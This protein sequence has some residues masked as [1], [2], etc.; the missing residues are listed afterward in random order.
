MVQSFSTL[1]EFYTHG[2]DTVIDVRSPSEFGEDHVP[3][4]INLPV[5]DDAERAE[6][7]TIYVQDSPFK[8]RKIGAALVAKNSS[9]HLRGPL[10]DHPGEWK[11]LVYCWRGGQRSGSFTS[12][13]NQIGWRA[14]VVEG[15]YRAYRRLVVKALYED[16]FRAPVYLIDGNTGTAKTDIL[17]AFG[18]LGGQIIDLEGLAHHRGSLF[19][20]FG[21]EQP[22]QK[23]F[24]G[25]LAKAVHGLDASRPVLIEAESSKI[26]ERM[27]PPSIWA[28][29][30]DA[31]RV[32][33]SAPLEARAAYL[34]R[35]YC[36]LTTDPGRLS[37]VIDQLR[38]F[39]SAAQIDGWQAMAQ[40]GNFTRLAGGLMEEH[41]DPRY[42]KT[43]ASS[44]LS[45]DL[46]DLN[47]GD[48][49]A[50]AKEI[51]SFLS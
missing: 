45:L 25:A 8:A 26:G 16:E 20:G 47:G 10:C 40:E 38:P 3:G 50:A 17:H 27:V 43:D 28:A 22:S 49:E 12:I 29:M 37:A 44:V 11:P 42:R 9:I 35:A 51:L 13:L 15:G 14:E 23:A 41:Y 36:D 18:R 24:E 30:K 46:R 19:G 31:P 1:S 7:G 6:V 48:I 34:T 39:Y 32:R 5:L 33:I 2:F 4:A 21:D